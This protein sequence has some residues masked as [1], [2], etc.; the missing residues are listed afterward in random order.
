MLM[1]Y[2]Q[3]II[4]VHHSCR[5]RPLGLSAS[6]GPRSAM[7][8]FTVDLASLCHNVCSRR[9]KLEVVYE[10]HKVQ[11]SIMLGAD[12]WFSLC[13]CAGLAIRARSMFSGGNSS[14]DMANAKEIGI[15]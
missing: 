12:T 2:H 10:G 3:Y 4:Y 15:G 1:Y 5:R 13:R 8:I 11:P 7:T 6:E 9:Q 14:M